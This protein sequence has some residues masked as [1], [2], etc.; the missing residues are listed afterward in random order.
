MNQPA[1]E[2]KT[3]RKNWKLLLGVLLFPELFLLLYYTSSD[4]NTQEIFQTVPIALGV[5]CALFAG[6]YLMFPVKQGQSHF[7]RFVGALALCAFFYVGMLFCLAGEC[8][9]TNFRMD[10]R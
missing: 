4:R 8:A 1:A 2:L 10:F 5:P 3:K 9:M 6:F 7:F